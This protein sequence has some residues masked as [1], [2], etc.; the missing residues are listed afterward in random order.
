MEKK[1]DKKVEVPA[2][3]SV[4]EFLNRYLVEKRTRR[5]V[6]AR[7]MGKNFKSILRY[8][9]NTSIKTEVLWELSYFDS[10]VP[11]ETAQDEKIKALELEV[12]LLKAKNEA[13]MEVL[14]K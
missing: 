2:S 13:L 8:Q 12:A 14:K 4:G 9:R 10:F 11:K 5:A 1:N 3:P 7:M 6:L